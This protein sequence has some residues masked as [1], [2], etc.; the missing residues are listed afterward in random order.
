MVD[1]DR[2]RRGGAPLTA[3]QAHAD[4]ADLTAGLADL[5]ALV[6]SGHS[7]GELLALVASYGVQ[8]IPGADGVGVALLRV[9]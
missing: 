9:E 7:L 3:D 5:A 4:A 6:A 2:D 8:A 1:S